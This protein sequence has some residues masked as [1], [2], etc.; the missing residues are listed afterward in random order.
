MPWNKF[1]IF[2]LCILLLLPVV[3]SFPSFW[4]PSFFI[5]NKKHIKVVYTHT[6]MHQVYHPKMLLSLVC[7]YLFIS[8]I[9]FSFHLVRYFLAAA[10]AALVALVS[11]TTLL[12]VCVCVYESLPFLCFVA[13]VQYLFSLS[14]RN[15]YWIRSNA[16]HDNACFGPYIAV[17]DAVAASSDNGHKGHNHSYYAHNMAHIKCGGSTASRYPRSKRHVE[18]S[19]KRWKSPVWISLIKLKLTWWRASPKSYSH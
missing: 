19:R 2:Y 7:F 14:S 1:V 8:F 9:N 6:H 5:F 4:A 17:C 18:T 13:F 11:H 3:I 16:M 12:F 15:V 10:A